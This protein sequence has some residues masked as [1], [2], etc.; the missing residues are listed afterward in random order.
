MD[1]SHP[2]LVRLP[3]LPG[4]GLWVWSARLTWFVLLL[5]FL[6]LPGCGLLQREGPG[7]KA[8]EVEVLYAGSLTAFLERHL[9]PAFESSMGIRFK[10]EGKGSVLGARLIREGLRRPD[11]FVSADPVVNFRLMEDG[12][13]GGRWFMTFL[14]NQLVL[15]YNPASRHAP[16]MA[17]AGRGAIPWF[18]ALDKPGLRF[19]RTDPVLDPK[20]YR[21]S[22][23]VQLARKHY[24]D[25]GASRVLERWLR[26]DPF[27]EEHLMALL[28]TGQLDAALAYRNEAVERGLPFISLPDELNQGKLDYADFYAKA[29]YQTPAGEVFYGAPVFYTVTIPPGGSNPEEAVEYVRF[30]LRESARIA[31][32]HGF[33]QAP[34]LVG[35]DPEAVPPGLLELTQGRIFFRG[36][37]LWINL[38]ESAN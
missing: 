29:V 22:F 21:L 25:Q 1:M 15:A 11:V 34:V 7:R 14:A 13:S 12:N 28:E 2:G 35:G 19:G 6:S 8:R 36:G 32:E 18:R 27:P 5:L 10:G 20:G 37:R 3:R 23:M 4:G 30:L 24:A 16:E 17:A 38:E 9:G 31:G 33:V 26:S